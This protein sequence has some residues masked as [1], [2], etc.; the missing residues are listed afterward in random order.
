[1]AILTAAQLKALETPEFTIDIGGGHEVV[2]RRPDLQLLVLK[3]LLPTPLLGETARLVGAWAG[4]DTAALTEDVIQGSDNVL[5][6][7]N[8]YICA[9][10]VTPRVVMTA[11]EVSALNGDA[12]LVTDLTLGTKRRIVIQCAATPKATTEVVAAATEFPENGPS[13]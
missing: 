8:A 4:A 13:A 10:M 1:M 2:V 3:G 7:V 6:M 11:E 9:A 5:T 12:L